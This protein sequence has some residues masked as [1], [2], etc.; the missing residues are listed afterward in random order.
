MWSNRWLDWGTGPCSMGKRNPGQLQAAYAMEA[1]FDE[2]VFVL[3]PVVATLAAATVHP[4]AGLWIAVFFQVFGTTAFLLQTKTQP[5]FNPSLRG[6]KRPSVLRRPAMIVLALTYVATGAVFGAIDLSVVANSDAVNMSFA[7]G[8]ILGAMSL[9]SMLSALYYGS[10]VWHPPLWKLFMIGVLLIA[11]GVSTFVLAPNLIVLAILM[12]VAGMSVAPTMTNVNTIVQRISPPDR[13]TE[14]LTW[15]STAMTLGVSF[16]SGIAGP[17]ID[18]AGYHGGFLVVLG[19]GWV[20]VLVAAIGYKK[21]RSQIIEHEPPSLES[22]S[23]A[24][25][26]RSTAT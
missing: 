15:M 16:G 10:K 4:A 19:Y 21:L 11:V 1:A 26:S 6:Q 3:G 18:H 2:L 23:D 14:G 5:P 9:G 8:M 13:L 22:L 7:A 24:S 12:F 20:M 17:V 25:K